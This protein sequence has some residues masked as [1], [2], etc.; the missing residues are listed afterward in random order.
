MSGLDKTG[1]RGLGAGTGRGL[2]NCSPE[3][4]TVQPRRPRLGRNAQGLRARGR[5]N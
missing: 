1:P 4:K 2:G 3:E 5:N